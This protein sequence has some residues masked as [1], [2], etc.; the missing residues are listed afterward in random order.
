MIT[1]LKNAGELPNALHNS[2]IRCVNRGQTPPKIQWTFAQ[3][4]GGGR[5]GEQSG[6][7]NFMHFSPRWVGA[8]CV[9]GPQQRKLIQCTQT[10]EI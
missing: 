1:L 4:P 9:S 6:G 10:V 3:C 2:E 7:R 5:G 8:R